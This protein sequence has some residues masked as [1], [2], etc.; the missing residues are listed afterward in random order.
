MWQLSDTIFAPIAGLGHQPVH[1]TRISG[2]NTLHIAQTLAGLKHF[3]P[4]YAHYRPLTCPIT[5]DIIDQALFVYYPAP[6]SLTGEDCLEIQCH[7]S[8]A[9]YQ[10]LQQ[11]LLHFPD[12]RLAERGEFLMRAFMHNKLDITKAQAI[13]DLISAQSENQRILALR[14][15]DGA[16]FRHLHTFQ[17]RI[18]QALSFCEAMLDFSDDDLPP[19]TMHQFQD[20][21]DNIIQD[22]QAILADKRALIC[23][24]GIEVALLGAPNVGKSTLFNALLQ[25]EAAIVSPIAGTTRDR[26]EGQFTC[27]GF[28]IHLFDTA[29]IRPH[30]NDEIEQIGM[31]ISHQTAQRADIRLFM[32]DNQSDFID[33][34]AE[35][36]DIFIHNKSDLSP[37]PNHQPNLIPISLK[38]NQGLNQLS[39]KLADHCQK[40]AGLSQS[41]QLIHDHQFSTLAT[42]LSAL[43][44][45][46]KAPAPEI[47][48]EELRQA[49]HHISC[50]TGFVGTEELLGRIFNSFCI[51]K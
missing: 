32:R 41:P 40:I 37:P 33:H 12:C 13:N 46:Q 9:I 51:G 11:A 31:N 27:A 23:R 50:I 2:K 20:M 17:E 36:H 26:L 14:N 29:G 18:S 34:I 30:S 43:T 16:L 49:R 4:R 8:P 15:A 6:H 35:A 19:S 47:C 39:Q 21:L 45:A 48:A 38:L 7:G 28:V 42:A 5:N 10:R 22:V 1:I 25:R 44:N 24:Q 3:Q